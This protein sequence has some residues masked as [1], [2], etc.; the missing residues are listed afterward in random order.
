M[1]YIDV[2]IHFTGCYF[3]FIY[4]FYLCDQPK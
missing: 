3:I 2:Y 4:E 1:T